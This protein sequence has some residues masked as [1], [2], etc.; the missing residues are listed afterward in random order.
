[1]AFGLSPRDYFQIVTEHHASFK[2]DPLSVSK[3]IVVSILANH[4]CEHVFAANKG[5]EGCKDADHYREHLQ[6][7]KPELVLIRDLCDFAKHGPR[8]HR[9]TVRVEKAEAKHAWIP[10]FQ[11]LLAL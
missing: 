6:K 11:G 8:L 5:I 9:T 10:R 4:I 1:M 7:K 2:S 3:A